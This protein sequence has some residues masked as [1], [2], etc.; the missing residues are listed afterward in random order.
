MKKL[1]LS[2]FV[3]V[4]MLASTKTLAQQ[5]FGTNTPSKSA[6]VDIVSSQ[7]GLLIPRLNL[8]AANVAAP[9]ISPAQSLLVYNQGTSDASI[10]VAERVTPGFYYWDN[11]RWVR[12]RSAGSE[13]TTVVTSG[14]ATVVDSSV[15]TD[16]LTTTYKVGVT[17][18]TVGQVL[19]SVP[20]T[21]PATM[22]A[23]P[24]IS[25]W[26]DASDFIKGVNGVNITT[27][28]ATGITNVGIGGA[29]TDATGTEII[30]DPTTGKTLAIQGLEV[31]TPATFD[32][33]NQNI[34]VMGSNGILKQVSPKILME[35]AIAVGDLTAKKLSS[36]GGIIT[37]NNTTELTNSVLKD[38]EL[39]IANKSI[40]A[41]KLNPGAATTGQIATV[42]ESTP[43]NKEIQYVDP[44][45]AIGK[46]LTTDNI[47]QITGANA[48]SS[49]SAVGTVLKDIK[50]EIGANSITAAQ[51]AAGAVGAN[52]LATGAVTADKLSTKDSENG[53]AA[54]ENTVPVANSNGTVTYKTIAAAAGT[55][56]TTD[57]KIVIGNNQSTTQTLVD[58]V[59]VATQLSIKENSLTATEIATGA[60]TSDEI[61]NGTIKTEDIQAP[62]S[63]NNLDGTKNQV[64]VTNADGAVSWINQSAL[65]NKD[66]YTFAAP[67]SKDAGTANV[68][69]G[70]DYNVT[71]ATASATT[72]GVVKQATAGTEE[73]T[74][75]VDGTLSVNEAN[76][77]LSGDVTGSLNAT[78]VGAIQGT[79]VS[80]T[81]PTSTN[82]VLKYVE[83]TGG[84]AGQWVPSQL[85]G[86]DV[87][88]ATLSSTSIIVSTPANKALLQDLNIE[89]KPGTA[90]NQILTTTGTPGNLT[91]GW[92]T[93][94][95]LVTVANGLNKDNT[96]IELGGKLKRATVIE[97]GLNSVN[98][99]PAN[100]LAINGLINVEPKDAT[101]KN[102][103]I[104]AET[105]TGGILRT[106]DKVIVVTDVDIATDTNYSFYAPE[107]V[108][109]VTLANNDQTITFPS[110]ASA[111][112]QVI[113]IKIA[114]KTEAH[115]GYLNVLDTYGAMPYQAWIVKSNG[116][117]WEI[118]GR[119]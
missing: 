102:K 107:V 28:T 13:K 41:E 90:A 25:E 86:S 84:A 37:I 96:D 10:A 7:R 70:T 77:N 56:L 60:I 51:I 1:L 115:T 20:N 89:I 14:N 88:G 49:S 73:I 31:L 11:G 45:T 24:L 53:T 38:I 55:D 66:N 26:V 23:Q 54:P 67:L 35:D 32:P 110:A 12:F 81:Q 103:V 15:S 112:G 98:Q 18:G 101:K 108:I 118:V 111:E 27:D 83:G 64:M 2:A 99:S 62:G 105:T 109:S 50:L 57:G 92:A 95:S 6:A 30:T 22:V 46:D 113:N 93:P 119:N 17:T 3:A 43:G 104:V 33:A 16:G 58:A 5:G 87:N 47:I 21:D 61:L 78:K 85:Q 91:T 79:A 80:A 44:S 68:N 29:L 42:V 69:G 59:L 116:T 65:A 114:N 34:V 19:V 39:G 71:I 52:E 9:V 94:N 117:T 63:T 72:L 76:V 97:T 75:A 74:I 100:T 106:V 48:D 4:A 36:A 40:G 8:T 82:N